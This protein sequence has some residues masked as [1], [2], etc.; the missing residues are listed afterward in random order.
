MSKLVT[1]SQAAALVRDSDMV[2]LGG[3]VLHRT[4]MAMVRELIRQGK[5]GLRVVKTAGAIDIDMLCL[6]GCVSSVDAGFISYETEFGL[7]SFYRKAVESGAVKA[8]EHACYTVICALRAAQMGVPFMPVKG[9][10]AGDLLKVA[11]YFKVIQNPFGGEP[12]TVVKALNPD[13]AVIHV[14]EADSEGNARI[15][16]PKFEDV[17]ISRAAKKIIIT[18]EKIVHSSKVCSNPQNVDIP[19]FL[20][21]AVVHAPRGAMPCSCA[22]FYEIDGRAINLFKALPDKGGLAEYLSQYERKDRCCSDRKVG[23]F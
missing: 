22:S 17:L 15:I 20:V 5:S 2:A 18:S 1:L 16:G 14:Q 13:V 4:P 9:L 12:V 8:N 6:G 11:E 3:N 19:H 23:N 10:R 21:T 7:A